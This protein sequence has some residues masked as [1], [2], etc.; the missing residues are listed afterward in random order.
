MEGCGFRPAVAN[1]YLDQDVFRRSL[2]IF[3]EHVEIAIVI[4]YS[5]ISQLEFGIMTRSPAIFTDEPFIRKG[6][7]RI[8]VQA[9]QI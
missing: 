8:F 4:K 1:R 2:G 5:G 9:F 6:R 7:L 3:D